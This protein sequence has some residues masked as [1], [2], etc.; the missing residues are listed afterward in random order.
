MLLLN[1]VEQHGV[2]LVVL[3]GFGFARCGICNGIRIDFG[4]FFGDEAV[5][6]CSW[7]LLYGF[8]VLE[9]ME[10]PPTAVFA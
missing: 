7:V 5:L 3:D 8:V 9:Y 10:F 4:D 1:L 2:D 6:G